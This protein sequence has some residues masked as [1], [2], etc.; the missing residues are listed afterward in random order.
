MSEFSKQ[1]SK[2]IE[3]MY[4]RR[5]NPVKWW[6]WTVLTAHNNDPKTL[7]LD[8]RTAFLIFADLVHDGL[9]LPCVQGDG[10]EAYLMNPSKE[11]QWKEAISPTRYWFKQNTWRIFEWVLSAIVGGVVSIGVSDLWDRLIGG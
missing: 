6:R 4:E 2:A 9:F 10:L 3:W 5:D 11:E 7:A 8:E 1:R